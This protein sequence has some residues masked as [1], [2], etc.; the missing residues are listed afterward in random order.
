M[1]IVDWMIAAKDE[2]G[3]PVFFW[4]GD[5]WVRDPEL[6]KSYYEEKEA[7]SLIGRMP[8]PEGAVSIGLVEYES[9]EKE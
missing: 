4:D 2:K 1:K 8:V 6:G 5:R 7:R 3:K 9:D